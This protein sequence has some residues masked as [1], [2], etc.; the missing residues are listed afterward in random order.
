MAA[1]LAFGIRT[2][3]LVPIRSA[4]SGAAAHAPDPRRGRLDRPRHPGEAP[5]AGG[6]SLVPAVTLPGVEHVQ[7]YDCDPSATSRPWNPFSTST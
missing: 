1:R 6:R 7:A 2:D 3:N 5:G 4:R